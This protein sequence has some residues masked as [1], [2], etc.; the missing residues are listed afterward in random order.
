MSNKNIH[1]PFECNKRIVAMHVCYLNPENQSGYETRVIEETSILQRMGFR[2]IVA[3]FIGTN[4]IFSRSCIV[5][6]YRRLKQSTGAKIYILPTNH[7]F[8][9]HD[10]S[11]GTKTITLPLVA[12]ARMHNVNIL[13]GHALYSTIHAL[14]AKTHTKAKVIFDVHGAFPEEAEMSGSDSSRV[15]RLLEWEKEAL[16]TADLRIFVSSRMERFF[17]AK[18]GLSDHPYVFIPCCVYNEKFQMSGE[19]RLSKRAQLGIKEK[20][21]FLYL[22]TLSVW[23]CPEAM[24]SLF[25]QFYQK[26]PDSLFYLILPHFDHEKAISFLKKYK[27]PSKSYMVAEVPHMEVGSVIGIADAGLLLRK[28]HPVNY[29]SSPTKF[30]EYLAAGVPVISTEDIGDTSD[31]IKNEKVGLIISPNGG[32]PTPDDLERVISFTKDVQQNRQMWADRCLNTSKMFLDWMAHGKVL[33][34]A[35]ENHVLIFPE[36]T[37]LDISRS[38]NK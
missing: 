28:S 14:R 24:F 36:G 37:G 7:Y 3:C 27:L 26:R 6:F 21:V 8:D 19:I 1:K 35:Y 16:N 25:A 15:K 18:Y 30:G 22:G 38:T 32:G 34:R 29:V 13:H 23:Q 10:S 31:L 9:L 5:R 20:F 12:L 4:H 2:I 33:G 11:S 17:R